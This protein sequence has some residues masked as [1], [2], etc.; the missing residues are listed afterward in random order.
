MKR[1]ADLKKMKP[2]IL[3]IGSESYPEGRIDS[4]KI[5]E[6]EGHW[7]TIVDCLVEFGFEDESIRA[8]ID[9]TL[10]N[11]RGYLFLYLSPKLKIHLSAEESEDFFTIRLDTSLP[12]EEIVRIFEKHFQFPEK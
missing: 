9:M 4:F 12:R 1:E 7:E 11:P 6:N 5:D 10:E 8:D 3:G 2:K